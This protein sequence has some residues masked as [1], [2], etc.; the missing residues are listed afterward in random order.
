MNKEIQQW[1]AISH[2]T[3]MFKDYFK[4]Y[5]PITEPA[6]Q[7][8]GYTVLHFVFNDLN[9]SVSLQPQDVLD[10]D[11]IVDVFDCP[12]LVYLSVS[13]P[14]GRYQKQIFAD[15]NAYGL[16][17]PDDY[18]NNVFSR[19]YGLRSIDSNIE[20]LINLVEYALATWHEL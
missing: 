14:T 1:K 9:L 16:D 18:A 13:T 8:R 3:E 5:G 2:L 6:T 11:G 12:Y 17:Y 10:D 4:T 19:L 15:G 7:A 20:Q